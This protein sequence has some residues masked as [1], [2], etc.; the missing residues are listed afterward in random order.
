MAGF[1]FNL[2]EPAANQTIV[3]DAMIHEQYF[4]FIQRILDRLQAAPDDFKI[5]NF[6]EFL[7]KLVYLQKHQKTKI[8][9]GKAYP[10]KILNIDTRGHVSTFFAGMGLSTDELPNVYGDELGLMLGNLHEQSL[11]EIAT[12]SKLNRMKQDFENSYGVCEKEC[13]YFS[14]CGGGY[15]VRKYIEHGTF[16]ASET[17]FCKINIKTFTDA[18][19][20]HINMYANNLKV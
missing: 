12:S 14:I 4:R 13:D 2:E 7:C 11:E 16:E 8:S 18:F 3:Y 9:E 19:V 20:E 1:H 15:P 17:S 10:F 5:G 6:Y